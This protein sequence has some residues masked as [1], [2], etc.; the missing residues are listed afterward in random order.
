MIRAT[1]L[2]SILL[3]VSLFAAYRGNVLGDD[4]AKPPPIILRGV[5]AD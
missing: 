2:K 5:V 4:D 3:I 1:R